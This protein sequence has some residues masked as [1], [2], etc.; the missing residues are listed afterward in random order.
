MEGHQ[1][2]GTSAAFK[3]F[4]SETLFFWKKILSISMERKL[5][6]SEGKKIC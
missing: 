5:I 6:K 3:L 1:K 2:E 4:G